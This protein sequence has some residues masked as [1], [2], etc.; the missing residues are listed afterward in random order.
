VAATDDIFTT[1]GIPLVAGEPF[2]EP[3]VLNNTNTA[4]VSSW[5]AATLFGVANPLGRQFDLITGAGLKTLTVVGVAQ[6]TAISISGRRDAAVIYVPLNID[7]V[8]R[9][10]V[11]VRTGRDP[12]EI[13]KLIKQVIA[14][15]EAHVI[16]TRVGTAREMIDPVA[17]YFKKAAT[18]GAVLGVFAFVLVLA[19]IYGLLWEAVAR[20]S[21]EIGVRVALGATK[22]NIVR[23]IVGEGVSPVAVGVV[24][25]AVIAFALRIGVKVSVVQTA[26]LSNWV[27]IAAT[28]VAMV[29]LGAAACLIP[30]HSAAKVD[31]ASALR[32]L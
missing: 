29:V 28:G 10:L 20:R 3:I 6:D 25:G 7:E 1:L 4:V 18:L 27:V 23:T 2:R 19:G 15:P 12:R 16:L 17:P 11:A 30:A 14:S 22:A 13:T 9:V 32:T 31:A 5:T 21:A 8:S 24:A 26:L